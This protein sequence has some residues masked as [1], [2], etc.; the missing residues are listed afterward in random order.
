MQKCL[1]YRTFANTNTYCKTAGIYTIKSAYA[2]AFLLQW[3]YAKYTQI[4]VL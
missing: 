1:F 4:Q 2:L 3:I